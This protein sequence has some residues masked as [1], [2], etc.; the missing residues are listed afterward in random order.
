[1]VWLDDLPQ[2]MLLLVGCQVGLA[3]LADLHGISLANLIA[4]Q[5][6][7][8]TFC[9]SSPP[10][11]PGPHMQPRCLLQLP[12][13]NLT[14]VL[15]GAAPP[16]RGHCHCHPV[17]APP[18]PQA[19]PMLGGCSILTFVAVGRSPVPKSMPSV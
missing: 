3:S 17:A 8:C 7:L 11:G 19:A 13:C 9:T 12:R 16:R 6:V 15:A 2:N 4:R 14:E 10:M 1:M 18:P 5:H